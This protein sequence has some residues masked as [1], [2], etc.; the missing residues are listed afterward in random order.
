MEEY[1]NEKEKEKEGG[2][3]GARRVGVINKDTMERIE[4]FSML[5]GR[6]VSLVVFLMGGRK[7]GEGCGMR[8]YMMFLNW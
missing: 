8:E 5:V 2:R 4:R 6:P 3:G 7:D 1:E